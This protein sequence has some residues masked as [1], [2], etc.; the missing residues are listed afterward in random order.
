[1]RESNDLK[2]SNG[3]AFF[4]ESERRKERSASPYDNSQ[5]R[6]EVTGE[7]SP[8]YNPNQRGNSQPNIFNLNRGAFYLQGNAAQ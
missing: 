7:V 3:P 1:L 8:I 6:R 5:R 2:K 4:K